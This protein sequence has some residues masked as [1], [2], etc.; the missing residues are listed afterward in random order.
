MPFEMDLY[1]QAVCLQGKVFVGAGLC[2]Y[3]PNN[4]VVMVYD[5]PSERWSQLPDYHQIGGFAMVVVKNQLVLVGG[6]DLHSR[7]NT[8]GAWKADT[9]EWTRPY[10]HMRLPRT[11]C[12]AVAYKE[13]LVVAGG[14][15]DGRPSLP[16][17]SVEVMNTD[18]TMWHNLPP[19]P[20]PFSDMKTAVVGD[21][22]YFMGGCIEGG[23]HPSGL[24]ATDK[25]FSLS[26]PSLVA[27]M[28]SRSIQRGVW[29]EIGG[30][31]RCTPLSLGG[32]LLVL[33]GRVQRSQAAREIRC[34]QPDRDAWEE[35]GSLPSP[36]FNCACALV[37][38]DRREML[39][40]VGG[41]GGGNR[42]MKAVDVAL[43]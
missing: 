6:S 18:S 20:E 25:A 28:S 2:A 11:R 43:F 31:V 16:L 12:S 4:S 36:R 29:G 23:S 37:S 21:T 33:G 27:Q 7:V 19:M 10:P 22:C 13:W 14:L 1:V 39:V 24:T 41:C 9:R 5:I 3:N 8:L 30:F 42:K 17:P 15:S 34:Y 35:V 32:S 38:S 26:L 40:V